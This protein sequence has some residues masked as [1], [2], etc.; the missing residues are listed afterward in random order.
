[1][2]LGTGG[3]GEP[4]SGHLTYCTNIHPGESWAAMADALT[5]HVPGIKAAVSPAAPFG[6]G[7]RIA[8]EA[9]GTLRDPGARAELR[10]ILADTGTYP[11][12]INGF[13][14]GSFHGT[15]VKEN[16]YAPDWSTRERLDYTDGLADLLADLLPDDVATG[17]I[18]TVPVTF[19]DW[20]DARCLEVAVEN[21]LAHAARLVDIERERGRHIALALEPEP[22]CFLETIAETVRFFEDRLFVGAARRRL[23]DLARMSPAATEEA[24]RR[25]LGVCYDVCHAAVEYEDAA[26]SFDALDRAGIAVPKLQLSSA[27]RIEAMDSA[28]AGALKPFDE[29][30]Y[31]HQVVERG[32]GDLTRFLD[33]PDALDDEGRARGREWRVHFHVPVFLAELEAF[34]TTQGFLKEVIALHRRRPLSPHLEVETY[35]WDVLPPEYRTVEVGEA[36]A[37][38]L[39]W[40]L[41]ELRP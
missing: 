39:N 23:A 28:A 14:F 13:P 35:T 1:M 20:A 40:V 31:L 7:L 9:A 22:C 15:R 12:T 10:D 21:L 11:F 41:G 4:D 33:L 25:H 24:L 37:R 8:A 6:L 38:E 16:V 27:L 26:G 19:R 29:P 18:S 36:I 30:V 3:A 17:S 5:R 32:P 2:R 34:S